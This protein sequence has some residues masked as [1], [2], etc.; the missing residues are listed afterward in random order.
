MKYLYN[1]E[2]DRYY[3]SKGKE[4]F[5]CARDNCE[6]HRLG[7]WNNVKDT[8]ADLL[9]IISIQDEQINN[10]KKIVSLPLLRNEIQKLEQQ[11]ILR[12]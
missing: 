2:K 6:I 10:F 12:F 1:Q 9:N 7:G 8:I 11:K 5:G 3:S 4:L